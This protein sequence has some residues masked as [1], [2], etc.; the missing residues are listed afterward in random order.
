M[1]I[2]QSIHIGKSCN[3][4]IR[5]FMQLDLTYHIRHIA[6][7]IRTAKLKEHHNL[8]SIYILIPQK[9]HKSKYHVDTVSLP[10][11]EKSTQQQIDTIQLHKARYTITRSQN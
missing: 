3:I 2:E 11:I 10:I 9:I 5:S 6:Y 1:Q 4:E 8:N 7:A